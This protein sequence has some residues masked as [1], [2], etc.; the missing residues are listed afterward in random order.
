[1]T[2][3]RVD[4]VGVVDRCDPCGVG[5]F[6]SGMR[7]P[8]ALRDPGLMAVMP[9]A[10]GVAVRWESASRRDNQ[11]LAGGRAQRPPPENERQTD[12]STPQGS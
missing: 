10:L 5:G 9:A 11:P 7:T 2:N 6:F 3:G 4:P 1:M 8:G 12:V